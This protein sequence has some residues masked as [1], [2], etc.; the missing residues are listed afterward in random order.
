MDDPPL[1]LKQQ[2]LLARISPLRDL[3]ALSSSIDVLDARI[4]ELELNSG[5]FCIKKI[6]IYSWA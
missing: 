2:N 5:K 4:L 3:T 1:P 6:V